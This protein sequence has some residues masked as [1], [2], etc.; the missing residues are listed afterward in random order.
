MNFFNP[1]AF[2]ALLFGGLIAAVYFL[3]KRPQPFEVSA[4]FLWPEAISRSRTSWRWYKAPLPLLGLQLLALALL[5]A[6]AS[7]PAVFTQARGAGRL[8]LIIDTSASMQSRSDQGTRLARAQQRADTLV[9]NYA[10]AQFTLIEARAGGGVAVPLTADGAQVRA[11][12]QGMQPSYMGDAPVDDVVQ[13]VQSQ[14]SWS[15]FDRVIWFSDRRAADTLLKDFPVEF[16]L[17]GAGAGNAAITGFMVR[18]QPDASLGYEGFVRV[19]NF[20]TVPLVTTLDLRSGSR[21]VFNAPIEL[22]EREE[23][24]YTFP[25]SESVPRLLSARL[26]TEDALAF[27][28]ERHFTSQ[29]HALPRVL[30]WGERDRFLEQALRALGVAQTVDWNPELAIQPGDLLLVNGMTLPRAFEGSAL[31]VNADWEGMVHA[32]LLQPV[33]RVQATDLSHSILQGITPENIAVLQM[34]LSRLDNGFTPLLQAQVPTV[35]GE[36]PLLAAYQTA[37]ARVVWMGFALQDSNLRLTVDFPIL[38]S[39]ILRWLA[40]MPLEAAVLDTGAPLFLEKEGSQLTLPSQEA[41]DP[42]G[43]V[44]LGTEAP[45]FYVTDSGQAWAVNVPASESQPAETAPEV[46][47]LAPRPSALVASTAQPLWPYAVWFGLMV[48]ALEWACYERGW[49]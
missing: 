22:A 10:D 23:A 41:V 7:E 28:N 13:W 42:L 15:S 31:I 34:R 4:L 25:L 20:S 35:L 36:H 3:K 29:T 47:D 6:G 38:V 37:Q 12:I 1:L 27:D 11:A 14:G 24:D 33:G 40:P 5:V 8:A 17:Q 19:Q 21:L 45:G 32:E 2:A 44:F 46:L 9:G 48:L 16:D 49:L 43:R 18:R 30:W 26:A 39:N